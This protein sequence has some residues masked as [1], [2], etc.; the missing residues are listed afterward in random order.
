M[1]GVTRYRFIVVICMY[2][3]LFNLLLDLKS[4]FD[5]TKVPQRLKRDYCCQFCKKFSV[6]ERNKYQG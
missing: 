5:L 2:V 1:R 4:H 3:F 6:K